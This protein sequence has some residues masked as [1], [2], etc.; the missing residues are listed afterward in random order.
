[1]TKNSTFIGLPDHILKKK[2]R[3]LNS[4]LAY[5]LVAAP[6]QGRFIWHEVGVLDT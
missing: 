4:G 3:V 1:M 6:A 5:L 2:T